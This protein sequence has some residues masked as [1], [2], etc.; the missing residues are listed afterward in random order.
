M[1]DNSHPF[2]GPLSLERIQKRLDDLR[3]E[4]AKTKAPKKE[5]AKKRAAAEKREIARMIA[6]A[7][8][9]GIPD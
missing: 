7:F 1:N 6:Y 4:C 5:N 2:G 3:K 8:P 9:D